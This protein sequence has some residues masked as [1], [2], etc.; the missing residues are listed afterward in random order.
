MKLMHYE[1]VKFTRE[2]GSTVSQQKENGKKRE[3]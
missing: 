1:E 2:Y 3:H